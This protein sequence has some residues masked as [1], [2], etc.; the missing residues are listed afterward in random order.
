MKVL[1]QRP[2]QCGQTCVAMIAGV[3]IKEAVDAIGCLRGTGS[4][5]L[6]RGLR[7]LGIETSKLIRVKKD[8]KIPDDLPDLCIC[9]MHFGKL[10]VTHWVIWSGG[11][12]VWFD[13]RKDNCGCVFSTEDYIK[14][15]KR[16][17]KYKT[18]IT[19]YIEI[20]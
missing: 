17:P 14:Y 20:L 15:G 4:I 6:K 7:K 1:Q 9:L 10:S 8:Q 18:R 16:Y 5:A 3:S 13:P 19:S 12:S 11:K 2:G